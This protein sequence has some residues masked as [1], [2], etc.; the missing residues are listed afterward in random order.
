MIKKAPA[1]LT[2]RPPL[3]VKR[4]EAMRAMTLPPEQLNDS[5]LPSDL[6]QYQNA[7]QEP[8]PAQAMMMFDSVAE[9]DSLHAEVAAHRAAKLALKQEN[10][11]EALRR[12]LVIRDKFPRGLHA[13]AATTGLI[14]LRLKQ[15]QLHE[16]RG[17]LNRFL[18]DNPSFHESKD[19]SFLSG[20]LYRRTKKYK[21]AI[22]AFTHAL[23]SQYNEDAMYLRAWCMLAKDPKS[24]EA[25]TIIEDYQVQY[26]QGRYI[27]EIQRV[28][29][30]KESLLEP[31]P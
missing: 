18:K 14:T 29:Q 23:G 19:L 26:P 13:K 24:P 22:K 16:G 28:L 27:S 7:D 5:G 31:P 9:S 2:P 15:C 17:D 21:K 3:R 1:P 4:E 6:L 30:N 25:K 12:Y 10:D 20:E 8:N 11:D